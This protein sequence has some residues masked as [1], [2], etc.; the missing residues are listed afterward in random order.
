MPLPWNLSRTVLTTALARFALFGTILFAYLFF[1]PYVPSL[2]NPNE[3]TRIYLTQS[4]VEN[5]S[6]AIGQ[7]EVKGKFFTQYTDLRGKTSRSAFVND[8]AIVCQDPQA[9][10]P[11]CTGPLYAAKAPGNSLL[12]VPAYAVMYALGMGERP[13]QD[14]KVVW[15]LR[16]WGV[17]LPSFLFLLGFFAFVRRWQGD[18]LVA[19][20]ATFGLAMGTMAYPYSQIVASHYLQGA[21]LCGAF[22]LLFGVRHWAFSKGWLVAAGFLAGFAVLL[23]Y[24]A[25]MAVILMGLWVVIVVRPLISVLLFA[26]GGI[27]PAAFH[28]WYHYAAFGSPTRTGHHFLETAHNRDSQSGGFLGIEQPSLTNL[29]G[30]FCSPEVGLLFLS[31]WLI[32][33]IVG[34]VF[35]LRERNTRSDAILATLLFAAYTLFVIS[36]GKWRTMLG[37]T[38]GPRYLAPVVPF[39]ALGSVLTLGWLR[40]RWLGVGFTLA[41]ALVGLSVFLVTVSTIA[42]PQFN[43]KFSNP[44][45]ESGWA[46]L[47][48]GV[49]SQSL[50][51]LI[52]GSRKLALWVFS[53]PL[54]LFALGL[55]VRSSLDVRLGKAWKWAA[56]GA[57]QFVVAVAMAV[58]LAWGGANATH[59]PKGKAGPL[60]KKVA[61]SVLWYEK[62]KPESKKPGKNKPGKSKPGKSRPGDRKPGQNEP[63]KQK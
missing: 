62:K 5:A 28:A 8:T 57:V 31:P 35:W 30:S 11:N 37:W 56:N 51:T 2:N 59:T 39:L 46:L 38:I 32:L 50:V 45:F 15:L 61:D 63:I 33:G 40:R 34:L 9:E 43:P 60:L 26:L 4:I 17:I 16:V 20:V 44:I 41:V 58:A 14:A 12:A 3:N 47:R 36:L 29:W 53:V 21:F 24:P 19:H 25:A 1:L 27:G 52:G 7:K 55:L 42:Y 54:G 18:E 48:K 10:G 23:D 49:V 13:L 22:M 6:I